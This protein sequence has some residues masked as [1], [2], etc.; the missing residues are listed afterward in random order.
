VRSSARTAPQ[1]LHAAAA[2]DSLHAFVRDVAR[3]RA[4]FE[5]YLAVG[6]IAGVVLPGRLPPRRGWPR[7]MERRLEFRTRLGPVLETELGNAWPIVKIFRDWHFDVPLD[8]RA[9]RTVV[10]VGGHVGAFAVWAAARAPDARI[11]TFEPEPRNFSDL[12]LNV[13]RN[14]FDGR[15]ERVRAAVASEDGRR[16]LE[17]PIQ[18]NRASVVSAP[19]GETRVHEVDC[20]GLARYMEREVPGRIDVLKLDCEG[21]EWE[22][23]P[24]LGRE[25][26]GRIRHVLVGCHAR[27][28]A[29]VGEM[30][31][32]LAREGFR[33][34]VVEAGSDPEYP[35]LVTL[36]AQRA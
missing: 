3:T 30:E 21:A 22:I 17:A 7:L 5:N 33:A 24:S 2:R 18:R 32:L 14:G 36:W 27:E 8:W 12:E 35:L 4:V 29:E 25:T 26:F 23:L 20:I 15:I 16:V 6:A 31:A 28:D 13:R 10:E 9:V 11:V 1:R 34:R 19:V